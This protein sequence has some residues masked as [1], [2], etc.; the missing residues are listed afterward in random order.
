MRDQQ[1]CRACIVHLVQGDVAY[2]I[3]WPGLL[4][5]EKQQGWILPCVA[6]A[7]SDLVLAMPAV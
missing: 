7:R 3:E 2:R 1:A 4:P 6:M 5:E